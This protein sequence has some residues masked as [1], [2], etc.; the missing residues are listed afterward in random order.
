[1]FHS[2]AHFV[3]LQVGGLVGGWVSKLNLKMG[4]ATQA[5]VELGLTQA[6]TVSLELQYENSK[7]CH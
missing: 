4:L 1:M 7:D 2:R 5:V 3:L 6:K